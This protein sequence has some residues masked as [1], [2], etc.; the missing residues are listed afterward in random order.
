MLNG[1]GKFAILFGVLFGVTS[2]SA[3]AVGRI[4]EEIRYKNTNQISTEDEMFPEDI[5]F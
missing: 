3:I 5:P 4:A 2:G 1:F